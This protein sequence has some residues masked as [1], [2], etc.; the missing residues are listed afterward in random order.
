MDKVFILDKTDSEG[1]NISEGYDSFVQVVKLWSP[2][3]LVLDPW[4]AFVGEGID[5][6]RVNIVRPILQRLS[7]LAKHQ[8]CSILL[9]SHIGKRW[10]GDNINNAALGSVD[11][12]NASRSALYVIPDEDNEDGRILIHTKSNYARYGR[13]IKYRIS[14][15]GLAWTGFSSIDRQS[16]EEAVRRHK[17]PGEIA[18]LHDEKR[19]VNIQLFKALISVSSPERTVRFSYEEFKNQFGDRIFGLHQPKKALDSLSDLLFASGYELNAGIN[20]RTERG[21]SK[22]FSIGA[23]QRQESNY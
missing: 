8:D 11:F 15:D 6:N 19:A 14:D 21:C 3:L 2:K 20:I 12:I 17:T 10:Q 22:G 7:N 23:I 13:S 4:H 18:R 9:L 16:L 5:M 1:L